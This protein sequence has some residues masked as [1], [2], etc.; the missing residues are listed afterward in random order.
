MTNTRGKPNQ[1]VI[2]VED[3]ENH[4]SF[5]LKQ[6][7]VAHS[8]A[9]DLAALMVQSTKHLTESERVQRDDAITLLEQKKVSAPFSIRKRKYRKRRDR[10][11]VFTPES[12]PHILSIK[13]LYNFQHVRNALN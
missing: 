8:H 9:S 2:S 5:Q 7:G 12:S 10:P 3:L 1:M 11:G 13:G 6:V 4:Y